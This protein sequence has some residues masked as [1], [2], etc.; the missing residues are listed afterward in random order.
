MA[1]DSESTKSRSKIKNPPT[2][3]WRW[4]QKNRI[5][6]FAANSF[7]SPRQRTHT[8]NTDSN[9]PLHSVSSGRK[10]SRKKHTQDPLSAQATKIQPTSS[11]RLQS[12]RPT[13]ASLR[14]L[15]C[16]PSALARS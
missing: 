12:P 8:Y 15:Q 11:V 2:N 9:T 10:R 16:P 13:L 14:F 5:Q 4:D 3:H 1:Q 6:L 7:A